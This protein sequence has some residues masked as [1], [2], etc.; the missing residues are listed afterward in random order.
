MKEIE[1]RRGPER[2][3][4]DIAELINSP[5]QLAA[6]WDSSGLLFAGQQ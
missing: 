5:P 2:A 6:L 1:R 4:E 3:D